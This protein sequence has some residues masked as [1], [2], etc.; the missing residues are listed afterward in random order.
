MQG[1]F[2]AT[3]SRRA[4]ALV[5]FKA[6]SR[7]ALVCLQISDTI[8]SPD[9]R[10]HKAAFYRHYPP[11]RAINGPLNFM[12]PPS[13][14]LFN[15]VQKSD[16]GQDEDAVKIREKGHTFKKDVNIR[17][18]SVPFSLTIIHTL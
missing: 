1:L 18:C 5:C 12:N 7:R 17:A 16:F 14:L 11:Q 9:Q 8:S 13:L 2:K 4:A 10:S 6:S 15:Q 3:S